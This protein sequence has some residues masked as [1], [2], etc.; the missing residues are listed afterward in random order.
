MWEWWE[1][2]RPAR[3]VQRGWFH[4]TDF[5]FSLVW[6][7]R[8]LPSQLTS[9][10]LPIYYFT[11]SLL[12]SSRSKLPHNALQKVCPRRQS[13]IVPPMRV[14]EDLLTFPRLKFL[15]LC[16]LWATSPWPVHGDTDCFLLV[17]S[18]CVPWS[19]KRG[20][21]NEQNFKERLK[22]GNLCTFHFDF[23]LSCAIF[24]SYQ[25]N[26]KS[27]Q[28]NRIKT[29]DTAWKTLKKISLFIFWYLCVC[30]C[31]TEKK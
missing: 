10:W 18:L 31:I 23:G 12:T 1:D 22:I 29:L 27:K 11:C 15:W 30:H 6:R 4:D 19:Q 28:I 20:G 5:A 21:L 2:A 9:K 8:K 3:S 16:L 7:Q 24:F 17:K 13:H 26:K 14:T 25:Q